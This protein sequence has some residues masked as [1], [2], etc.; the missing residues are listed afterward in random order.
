[1]RAGPPPPPDIFRRSDQIFLLYRK[2]IHYFYGPPESLKSWAAQ[3]AAAWTFL[4]GQS[5]LYLDFENDQYSFMERMVALSVKD[6]QGIKERLIY[7]KP[8]KPFTEKVRNQLRAI[9]ERGADLVVVD[10][11]SNA[12]SLLGKNPMDHQDLVEFEMMFLRPLTISGGAVVG[13]D[14]T[15]KDVANPTLFGGQH[16]KAAVTGACFYF[17]LDTPFGRGLSGMAK[18]ELDKD[19]PGFLRQY[20]EDKVIAE[21]HLHSKK[22]GTVL[23]ELNVPDMA[24]DFRPTGIM[25]ALSRYVE[26]NPG[27]TVE[28]VKRD[29]TASEKADWV[30]RAWQ[31]LEQEGWV[32][33]DLGGLARSVKP[34]RDPFNEGSLRQELESSVPNGQVSPRDEDRWQ[35]YQNR[36]GRI[37]DEMSGGDGEPWGLDAGPAVKP[38]PD[39]DVEDPVSDHDFPEQREGD[40]RDWGSLLNLGGES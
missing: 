25:E 10:G 39:P 12:M 21:L 5:V 23:A 22:D 40:G 13:I 7:L 19:K 36:A 34:Y 17:R 14:H 15:P 35:R 30:R 24:Q 8:D 1:M 20:V 9:L 6:E 2:K 32:S 38:E 4:D 28:Q 31:L 16:K 29:G 27:V 33:A 3:V 26:A 37:L 18:M 11:I